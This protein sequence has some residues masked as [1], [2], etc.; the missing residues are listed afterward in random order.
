MDLLTIF[1]VIFCV[2]ILLWIANSYIPLDGRVKRIL[3]IVVILCLCVWLLRAF[4]I[5]AY[6]RGVHI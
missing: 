4:G 6:L 2:G 5:L 3:N 1:A